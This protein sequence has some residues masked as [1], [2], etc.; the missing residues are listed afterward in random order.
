MYCF[1]DN[2]F[3]EQSQTVYFGAK[4]LSVEI[5][6]NCVLWLW[7]DGKVA[8][9]MFPNTIYTPTLKTP[10]QAQ[11]AQITTREIGATARKENSYHPSQRRLDLGT[12]SQLTMKC[13]LGR[14]CQRHF[15]I[16]QAILAW[17]PLNLV[18]VVLYTRKQGQPT[19]CTGSVYSCPILKY[20]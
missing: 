8:R 16:H 11:W 17:R 13:L 12:A 15:S 10:C 1:V 6:N 18:Q 14:M 20:S 4:N 19:L 7:H 9:F 3:V 2:A 5:P